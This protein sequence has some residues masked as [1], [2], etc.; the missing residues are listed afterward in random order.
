MKESEYQSLMAL[1]RSHCPDTSA[2]EMGFETRLM[3]RLRAGTPAGGLDEFAEV[4]AAW[5][6]RSIFGLFPVAAAG[7]IF[8]GLSYG[9]SMPAEAREIAAHIA[10]WLPLSF[11]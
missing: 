2:A 1:A 8:F 3:A 9:F 11:F 4:F 6:W 5:L 10:G 7:A